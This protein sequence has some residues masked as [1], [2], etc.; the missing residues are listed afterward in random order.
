MKRAHLLVGAV[1]A[2][3][4][5]TSG[6]ARAD[7]IKLLFQKH[8]HPAVGD[9]LGRRHQRHVDPPGVEPFQQHVLRLFDEA[10]TDPL[11]R[12]AERGGE[13]RQQHTADRG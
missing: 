10:Q 3:M 9:R 1:I 6:I 7:E 11:R 8:L 12:S 5:S 13:R 2:M 4:A